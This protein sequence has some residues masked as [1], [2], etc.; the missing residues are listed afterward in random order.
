MTSGPSAPA[1]FRVG[2]LPLYR[3]RSPAAGLRCWAV[4]SITEHGKELLFPLALLNNY[5]FFLPGS[6]TFA[7]LLEHRTF[8]WATRTPD[9]CRD[10]AAAGLLEQ[11]TFAGILLLGYRNSGPFA[12]MLLLLLGYR[13]SGPFAGILLLLGYSNSGPFAGILL[14]LRWG[15]LSLL[16]CQRRHG[17]RPGPE[18]GKTQSCCTNEPLICGGQPHPGKIEARQRRHGRR[19][20]PGEGKTQPC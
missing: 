18:E 10:P 5:V 4:G 8:C 9:L 16:L 1:P 19:P 20:G 6:S 17:R 7:G 13:N 15:L 2:P 11:R 12:G 3:L 14:L